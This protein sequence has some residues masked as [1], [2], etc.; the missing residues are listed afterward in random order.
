M[1]PGIFEKWLGLH[2]T[3]EV[4]YVVDGYIASLVDDRSHTPIAES[5]KCSNVLSAIG[6]LGQKLQKRGEQ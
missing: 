3:I 4:I 2:T 6:S 1:R 5:D